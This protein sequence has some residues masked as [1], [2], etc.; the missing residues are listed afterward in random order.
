[1]ENNLGV[2][3]VTYHC[4][5]C[6]KEVD[7]AILMNGKLTAN[8][9]REVEE[10]HGKK[11]LAE[12]PCDECKGN[13]EKAYMFIIANREKSIDGEL[14]HRTGRVIGIKKESA[15]NIINDKKALEFGYGYL[16]IE[17]AKKLGVYEIEE[18]PEA[19]YLR[20]KNA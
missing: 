16:D 13:L 2:A 11:Y 1:M 18:D 19:A 8:K 5:I 4:P 10:Q 20:D 9:K 3:A 17:D 12:E 6:L 14:P 7:S 15:K